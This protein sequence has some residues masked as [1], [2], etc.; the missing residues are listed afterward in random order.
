MQKRNTLR[1]RFGILLA[2]AATTFAITPGF[3][4]SGTLEKFDLSNRG[5][6]AG[7]FLDHLTTVALSAAANRAPITSP[8]SGAIGSSD[9]IIQWDKTKAIDSSKDQHLD[10][11]QNIFSNVNP[12]WRRA[13][14]VNRANLFPAWARPGWGALR[15]WDHGWYGTRSFTP[16]TWWGARSRA[17]GT[18]SLA[19][20]ASIN[21]AVDNAINNYIPYII[22]PKTNYKLLY[23]TE[24]PSGGELVSFVVQVN[25]TD[26]QLNANCKK[27]T[28]NDKE[29]INIEEAELLNAACQVAYGPV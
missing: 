17:W 24:L 27:G 22:V 2:T 7:S 4:Q 14:V 15:P 9:L 12:S 8:M 28:L 10:L 20:R 25:S 6:D 16:W 13:A 29:P 5:S 21:K 23:G 1:N 18:T 26:Y 11:A 3:A 19:S